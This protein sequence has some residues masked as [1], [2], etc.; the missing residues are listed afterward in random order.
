MACVLSVLRSTIKK[1]QDITTPK[2]LSE[3]DEL[4]RPSVQSRTKEIISQ[5]YKFGFE[6]FI[7]VF[8]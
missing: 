8:M 4:D 5:T 7:N 6:V 1:L 3:V 2:R